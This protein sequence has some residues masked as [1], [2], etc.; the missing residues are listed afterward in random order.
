METK[1]FHGDIETVEIPDGGLELA[2]GMWLMYCEFGRYVR[3]GKIGTACIW[4]DH[5]ASWQSLRALFLR[6]PSEDE[7]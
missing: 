7:K 4:H 1:L 6:Q 2:P 3:F 5:P